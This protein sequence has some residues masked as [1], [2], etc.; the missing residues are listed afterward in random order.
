MQE[1]SG[2]SVGI[3]TICV[4]VHK[5]GLTRQKMRFIMS[6]R[7]E[8]KQAEFLCQVMNIP[9]SMFVFVGETESNQRD[10]H[11]E[12][13]YGL[14]GT[15]P[16]NLKIIFQTVS[17]KRMLAIAAMSTNGREGFYLGEGSV[18]GKIFCEYLCNSL[19]PI[20]QPFNGTNDNSI[21]I[22]NNASIHHLDEVCQLILNTG[23]LLWL[24]SPDLNPIELS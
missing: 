17:G 12:Y 22:I 8:D 3:S 24:F 5:L 15:A 1:L 11:R 19:L 7:C 10:L 21:V 9:A 20:L 14:R 18:D 16:V 13:G 6:R 2:I 23:S 4:E